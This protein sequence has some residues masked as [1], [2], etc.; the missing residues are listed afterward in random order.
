[1]Q[2]RDRNSAPISPWMSPE[3]LR[4]EPFDGSSDVYSFGVI[5]W[6]LLTGTIP[7]A[8][9]SNQ[10]FIGYVGHDEDFWVDIGLGV[11]SYHT[12][13]KITNQCLNS[14]PSLRPSFVKIVQK[15]SMVKEE[16]MKAS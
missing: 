5:L 8:E 14:D 10:Q 1:M 16:F 9:L 2:K 3:V 6:E 12:L 13:I 7:F 4:G 11:K 15:V